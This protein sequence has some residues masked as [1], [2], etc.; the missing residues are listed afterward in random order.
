MIRPSA[1]TT[2]DVGIEQASLN[3]GQLRQRL[4]R[5]LYLVLLFETM[6]MAVQGT[7]LGTLLVGIFVQKPVLNAHTRSIQS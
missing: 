6:A 4:A 3:D 5:A 2:A 1:R 7:Y